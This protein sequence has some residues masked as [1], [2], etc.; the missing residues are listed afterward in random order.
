MRYIFAFQNV[1]RLLR[2][3]NYG[4]YTA[5]NFAAVI[6]LWIQRV[7]I[8]WATW[9][10]TGSTAWLGLVAFAELIPVVVIGPIAGAA[11]DRFDRL[12]LLKIAQVLVCLTA[13]VE[14]I[15]FALDLATIW[16]VMALVLVLGCLSAL[17]Q[18]L[19]M[20]IIPALVPRAD[21]AVAVA[22]GAITFNLARFIGP[23]IAGVLIAGG[24]IEWGF[25]AFALSYLFFALT[26]SRIRL[27]DDFRH[28]SPAPEP[29]LTAI[30]EGVRYVGQHRGILPMMILMAGIGL[31]GRPVVE[32]LP[33]FADAVYGAGAGGLATFASLIGGGAI[34]GGI[35]L[36]SRPSTS[37][38][39]NIVLAAVI[40]TALSIGMFCATRSFY[41]AL[42]SLAVLGFCL[43]AVSVSA[44]TLIQLATPDAIRG[45]VLSLF[46]IVIRGMPALGAL[47][48]GLLAEWLGLRLALFAGALC[49]VA[50]V[51]LLMGRRRMIADQ[52]E[53]GQSCRS[54]G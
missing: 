28:A 49:L 9:Q 53:P 35:W 13:I 19:R 29:I 20:A 43:V 48:M 24:G 39:T 15:L 18:P 14:T 50:M 26:L 34:T 40:G 4:F 21:L 5:G 30:A 41:V 16:A 37:G 51:L 7:S 8:G 17:S 38:L 1:W 12:K 52:L 11:S 23:A 33:G 32:L 3:R 31:A 47:A 2:I 25:G 6:G 36:S 42:P 10:L 45:R 54:A 46:G 44:Q 27:V 22:L